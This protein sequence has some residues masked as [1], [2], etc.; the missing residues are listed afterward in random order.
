MA[1]TMPGTSYTV[2]QGDTLFSI[3]QQAYG[4]SNLWERIYL[5]NKQVIGN[6]P[7]HIVPGQVLLIPAVKT[8]TVTVASGLN[9]RSTPSSQ[10]TLITSYSI[11]TAL[12]YIEVVNGENVNGNPLWGHS[13]Q[14]HYYW[15]GGTDHPNG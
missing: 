10:S 2:Q 9:I 8:C 11:G 12:N 3:A 4:D 15:M 14:D 13:E 7:N 1:Q 5:V 6:D